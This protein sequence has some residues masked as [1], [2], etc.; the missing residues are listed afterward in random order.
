MHSIALES[1]AKQPEAAWEVPQC[2][3]IWCWAYTCPNGNTQYPPLMLTM[4]GPTSAGS[5]DEVHVDIRRHP[6][7]PLPL[8]AAGG[9]CGIGL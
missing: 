4:E 3:S 8:S 6:L 2:T 1:A 5:G 9:V 7:L